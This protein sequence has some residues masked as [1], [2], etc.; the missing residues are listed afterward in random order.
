MLT[1][2]SFQMQ[3]QQKPKPVLKPPVLKSFWGQTNGGTLPL[4]MAL[5]LVDSSIWVISD[6]KERMQIARFFLAYKSMDTYEDEK[7]GEFKKR[8]NTNGTQ[9]RY[10][11]KLPENWRKSIYESLKQGDEILI[12]DLYVRDKRGEYYMAPDIRIIIN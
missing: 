5:Q 8:Q 4:D 2:F 12:T 9:I 7:T 6:K 1:S 10:E 11:N 3:A